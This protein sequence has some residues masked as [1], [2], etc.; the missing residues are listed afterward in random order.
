MFR[1]LSRILCLVLFVW[2]F[3][4][5]AAATQ[6]KPFTIPEIREW[7]PGKGSFQPG[8]ATRIVCSSSADAELLQVAE[9][10]AADY[11]VMFGR[12]LPVVQGRGTKGDIIFALAADK[13]LGEEGYTV[14]TTDRVQLTAPTTRGLYWG[15]QTLLQLADQNES[16]ALPRGTIRDWP[17][18][19]FRGFMLDCGRKFIPLDYLRKLVRIMGYYKLSVLQLHLNDNGFKQYFEHNWD[20]TYAAFRLE[21]DTFPGLTAR[22]GAYSKREF[23]DLQRQAAAYGVEIIPEIDIP[24]HSLAFTQYKPGIGSREYGMDHLDLFAPETYRFADALFREYLTGDEPVF[25]GPRV[26]IGTDEYSNARKEVVEQFRAFTDH[27]I[28]LVEGLGKQAMVWGALTHAAG[29]TPVKAD[30][31]LLG[32]WNNGFAD[33]KAMMEAGYQLVSIPDGLV[34]M[35]PAAGYYHDYL[36]EAYLYG[37][38]TPAHIGQAVFEERHPSILGGMFALWNDH[39]GNGISVKDIHHRLFPALQTM[40]AKMWDGTNV[41]FSY[42]AFDSLRQPLAEAPGINERAR[43]GLT[44]A[45][46]YEQAELLPGDTLPLTEIGYDYTVSFDIEGGDECPGTILFRSPNATFYLSDPIRGMLGFARDGYLNTFR[47][48]VLPGEKARI[49]IEGDNRSTTLY[50]NDSLVEEMNIQRRF[51]N[52][53]RDSMNYVRTLV[54]PLEVAG[55]FRSRIHHLTIDNYRESRCAA[56]ARKE[57]NPAQ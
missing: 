50:V 49:R 12:Q 51:Y 31:V 26:H 8:D 52:S 18:Y 35:V 34:Y 13:G 40:S 4:A 46:V 54:F 44:P 41:S 39:V 16:Q 21:S 24:A 25:I 47:Y 20:K 15:T 2:G 22:D 28:R 19:P 10:F 14:R 30:S 27:Y 23:I 11:A 55:P 42:P 37:H 36:D 33:P 7:V 5:A 53:G 1:R 29:E 38:W 6:S 43:I 48:R 32:A 9:R 45:R 56:S 3:S 17:E 57:E